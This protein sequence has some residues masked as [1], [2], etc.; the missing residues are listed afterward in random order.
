[1]GSREN[2]RLAQQ[3][4][5]KMGSGAS[6]EEIASLCTPDLDRNIPGDAGVLPW[7]GPKKGSDAILAFIRDTQT[8]VERVSLDITDVLASDARVHSR[9][10]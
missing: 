4:L 9:A 5:E 2:L 3:F 10:I 6:A 8:M 1:M 7:I